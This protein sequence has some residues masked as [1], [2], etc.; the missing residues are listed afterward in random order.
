MISDVEIFSPIFVY[1][2]L[3][4]FA[5]SLYCRCF[6]VK[7]HLKLLSTLYSHFNHHKHLWIC[8]SLIQNSSNR[9]KIIQLAHV[10]NT[11]KSSCCTISIIFI[12][13]YR[14]KWKR[15]KSVVKQNVLTDFGPLIFGLA[16]DYDSITMACVAWQFQLFRDPSQ[17]HMLRW[18]TILVRLAMKLHL[19]HGIA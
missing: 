6:D 15:E 7:T 16:V 4:P 17:W 19:I 9:S 10:S 13:M 2:L 18:C 11:S 8:T 14:R 5:Y 3:Y 1:S 12:Q